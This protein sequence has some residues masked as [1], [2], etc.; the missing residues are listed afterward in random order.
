M[1]SLTL[2]VI[3]GSSRGCGKDLSNYF[4]ENNYL[5]LGISRSKSSIINENFFEVIGDLNLDSTINRIYKKIKE[6]N[7]KKIILINCAGYIV[8]RSLLL[9]SN[10]QIDTMISTNLISPIKL[11]KKI[12]NLMIK[13]KW[14]RIISVSSV[15]SISKPKGDCVYAASKRGLEIAT[16]ILAKE[17]FPFGITCNILGISGYN[18]ELFRAIETSELRE[19]IN[20]LP[21][22]L[23]A[24]RNDISSILDYY[25]SDC[26]DKITG[27][28]IFLGGIS[29]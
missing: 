17:L 19:Y 16:E 13:N 29:T 10:D 21:V 28:K 14:G 27:Q 4:L 26:S 23:M 24:T 7:V 9:T 15:A 18:S 25:I 1:K 3:T 8:A 11:M 5:V 12:S 2:V 20:L 6:I 22:P